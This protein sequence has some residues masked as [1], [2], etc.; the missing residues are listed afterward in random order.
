[1]IA[2]TDT[3][4]SSPS[5]AETELFEQVGIDILDLDAGVIDELESLSEGAHLDLVAYYERFERVA[6]PYSA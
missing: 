1:M 4:T 2:E 5:G 3:S 6:V